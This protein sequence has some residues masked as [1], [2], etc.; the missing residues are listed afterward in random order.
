MT[1]K[2]SRPPPR[3]RLVIVIPAMDNI[4]K[5]VGK[6]L[7]A[8]D[9]ASAVITQDNLTEAAFARHCQELV[10]IIQARGVAAL[11]CDDTRAAGRSG[12]D[13]ILVQQPDQDYREIAARFSP[14]KIVGFGGSLNRHRAL[15]LGEANPDFLFFGKVNGDIR[16]EPHPKNLALANWWSELV[17]IPCVIMGGSAVESVVECAASGA[18]FVALGLAVFADTDGPAEAVRRANELLDEYGPIFEED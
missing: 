14:Q 3:C 10:P 12:A 9:V 6:A 1:D 11:V 16:P 15:E 18:E 7:D 4:S 8:G 5:I 2:I 17:A 13:G